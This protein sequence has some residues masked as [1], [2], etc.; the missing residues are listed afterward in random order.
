MVAREGIEPRHEDF[1]WRFAKFPYIF[2]LLKGF[3]FQ[4]T[5]EC[6]MSLSECRAVTPR[7]FGE[8]K[9][10]LG[11]RKGFLPKRATMVSLKSHT[12]RLAPLA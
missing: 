8:N 11:R 9:M 10:A 2:Q 6:A 12:A 3:Q 5:T 7:F 1:Q 4:C